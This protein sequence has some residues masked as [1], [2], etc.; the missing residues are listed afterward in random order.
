MSFEQKKL[1]KKQLMDKMHEE[2]R[3]WM[4]RVD[5]VREESKQSALAASRKMTDAIL[6]AVIRTFGMPEGDELKLDIHIPEEREGYSWKTKLE[7]VDENTWRL[8]AKEVKDYPEEEE[9][10]ENETKG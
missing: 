2:R 6:S 5:R 3:M 1:T 10:Q 7:V 4:D 8:W 9:E